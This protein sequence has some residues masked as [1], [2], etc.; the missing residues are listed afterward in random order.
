M[1]QGICPAC[2]T[3]NE[4][5]EPNCTM[6][7]RRLPWAPAQAKLAPP[8]PGA[9]TVKPNN[10]QIAEKTKNATN[11]CCLGCLGVI[12]LALFGPM[13]CPRDPVKAQKAAAYS[14]AR[15]TIKNKL[16]SPDSAKFPNYD[17]RGVLISCTATDCTVH[18]YVDGTNS[19]GASIRTRWWVTM[20]ASGKD[21][22]TV[23]DSVIQE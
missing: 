9:S 4:Y 1:N 13:A 5:T 3:V 20:T 6:C 11:G 21:E 18:G 10:A 17:D 7:G 15:W 16:K 12:A 2:N 19:F 14:E 22:F 8:P 23:T